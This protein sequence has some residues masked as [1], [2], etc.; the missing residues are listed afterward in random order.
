MQLKVRRQ[1]HVQL[2]GI[3]KG[4]IKLKLVESQIKKP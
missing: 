3:G 4:E 1:S 2:K